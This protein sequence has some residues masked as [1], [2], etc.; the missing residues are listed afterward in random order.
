VTAREPIDR[1]DL[2]E[3]SVRVVERVELKLG[4]GIKTFRG[5]KI[6][7]T[8]LAPIVVAAFLIGVYSMTLAKKADVT[9]KQAV[10]DQQIDGVKT[11]LA[12]QSNAIALLGSDQRHMHEDLLEIK[13]RGVRAEDLLTRLLISLGVSTAPKTIHH[14]RAEVQP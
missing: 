3:S 8:A 11:Q 10:T 1:T 13:S 9:A 4:E 2:T 5:L 12:E 14:G 6:V 7:V